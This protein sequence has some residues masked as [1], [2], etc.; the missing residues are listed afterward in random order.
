M[1]P[2][3]ATSIQAA[4]PQTPVLV[5]L[6]AEFGHRTST[7]AQAIQQGMEIAIAEINAAGGVLGGRPLELVTRDNGSVTAR[8]VDDLRELAALPDMVAVF[9]G[10][11]SP[12]YV[13]SLPVAHELGIPLMDPWGAADIITEHDYRPSYT[14]RLSLKDSSAAPVMLTFAKKHYGAE[15]VGVLLPNTAWGRGNQKAIA[16]SAAGV[17]VELVGEQWYNWGNPSFLRHY[18]ELSHR[19]AQALLLVGNE[20]EGALL[21]KELAGLPESERLPVVSHWGVTGGDF[22]KLAGDALREVRLAVVQTYSFIGR[23]DPIAER[24]L[25]ALRE[26]YGV[27][28]PEF[29]KSPVGVAHA[30]DLTHLLARAVE[31]AGS[32]DRAAIR[33]ALEHLGP[34]QG[35]VRDY[36]RPFT[37]ERHDALSPEDVFMADYRE[38]DQLIPV[39]D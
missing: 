19:G 11:F 20:P 8:G 2:L 23:S 16:D 25:S 21:V 29:V 10:K 38:D 34:Y 18:L 37:P 14:F 30:Y 4:D 26:G 3:V 36:E 6:D 28:G 39:G 27:A 13:E 9:G 32:T 1:A 7:S 12:I 17:G 35:L 33:D 5:G 31:R 15:R 22:V 24:V